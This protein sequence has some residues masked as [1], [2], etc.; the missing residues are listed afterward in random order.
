M[1]EV[2]IKIT[3]AFGEHWQAWRQEENS[4][5][6]EEMKAERAVLSAEQEDPMP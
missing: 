2:E 1:Q 4:D 5:V 6:A 3:A